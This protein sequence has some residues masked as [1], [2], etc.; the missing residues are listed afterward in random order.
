MRSTYLLRCSRLRDLF[1]GKVVWLVPLI[2]VS[3]G[4]GILIGVI[5]AVACF[6]IIV[7]VVVIIVGF[8]RRH[9]GSLI[10]VALR[11]AGVK[12]A[13]APPPTAGSSLR[14]A[15]PNRGARRSRWEENTTYQGK[16]EEHALL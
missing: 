2:L 12:S 14:I 15:K 6:L 1:A 16:N 11:H 7:I 4:T 13:G 8:P 10:V 3:T 9:K 5:I